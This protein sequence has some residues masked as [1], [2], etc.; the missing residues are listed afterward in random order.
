MTNTIETSPDE[1]QTKPLNAA[2]ILAYSAANFGFGT[3]YALNSYILP[4]WLV[5]YHFSAAL[6]GLL[7]SSNSVEGAVIQPIVGAWSDRLRSRFGR[8]KPFLLLFIPISA[9]LILAT[10]LT[11]NI[12]PGIRTAAMIACILLFTI[13]F[14]IAADPYQALM[15]DITPREQRDRVSGFWY[16]VGILGQIA[17]LLIP[18]PLPLRFVLCAALMLV[19]TAITCIRTQEPPPPATAHTGAGL[20]E[21]LR[22]LKIALLGLKSLRQARLYLAMYFLFGA[23]IGAIHPHLSLFIMKIGHCSSQTAMIAVLGLLVSAGVGAVPAGRLAGRYGDKRVL[24]AGTAFIGLASLGGFW[25]QNL[26]QI[27]AVLI[28]AGLGIA[29]QNAT[30][31]P[32]LTRLVPAEEVGYYT[33]L[34]T[35]AVSIASPGAALI[36]G[37]LIDHGTYRV[38]FA[39]CFVCIVSS[40]TF[41]ARIDEQTAHGEIAK[42]RHALTTSSESV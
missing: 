25:V 30:A 20:R 17:I 28:L 19:M 4:Q 26:H 5:P 34:Q 9:A 38:I 12:A 37:F 7:A 42:R 41:L 10:P 40:A 27:V 35:T 14:N 22:D 3:F 21:H 13:C 1:E 23:G 2:G 29:A 11:A 32:L 31:F 15:A 6:T 8:R 33:G 36:T 24:I 39:V 18:L 16:F